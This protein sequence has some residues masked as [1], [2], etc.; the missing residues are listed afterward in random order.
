MSIF[1]SV[2]K[3]E[4]EVIKA[5]EQGNTIEELTNVSFLRHELFIASELIE[6]RQE[7]LKLLMTSGATI[8]DQ[9]VDGTDNE[10]EEPCNSAKPPQNIQPCQNI[11]PK[12]NMESQDAE[13]EN[14]NQSPQIRQPVHAT[15]ETGQT[16][17]IRWLPRQQHI[18]GLKIPKK[19]LYICT[20]GPKGKKSMMLE[21]LFF[22]KNNFVIFNDA[23][24]L[25]NPISTNL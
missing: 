4:S 14:Q 23:S 12:E 20:K 21:K 15:G 11:Q 1:E 7:E 24:Y 6:S 18:V 25:L 10:D 19:I 3:A 9:S 17:T 5:R 2:L 16:F 22:S 8:N 13:Q